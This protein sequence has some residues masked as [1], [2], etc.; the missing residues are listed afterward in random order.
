MVHDGGNGYFGERRRTGY[1]AEQA[2]LVP[3]ELVLAIEQINDI[4]NQCSRRREF[5]EAPANDPGVDGEG[6]NI[7]QTGPGIAPT[8][9]R[10]F[11]RSRRHAGHIEDT[12]RDRLNRPGRKP[13]VRIGGDRS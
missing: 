9:Q 1:T 7:A 10:K 8:P 2:K 13:T 12:P 4:S 6:F 5:V 11:P 3:R